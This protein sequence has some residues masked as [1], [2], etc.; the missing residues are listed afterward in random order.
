M[1]RDDAGAVL[2][3]L[4]ATV[5]ERARGGDGNSYTRKLL[6]KGVGECAKKLGEEAVETAIA[7]V[8]GDSTRLRAEAAD[9]LY[10]LLVLLEAAGVSLQEVTDELRARE[11]VS[12]LD[13]KAARQDR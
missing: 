1:T 3:R 5:A 10:H 4:A 2:E 13:E 6:A 7:A 9:V 8:Q 12:G 11:G